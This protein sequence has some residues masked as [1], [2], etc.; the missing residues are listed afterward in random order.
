MHTISKILWGFLSTFICVI[1]KIDAYAVEYCTYP[2]VQSALV[3]NTIGTTHAQCSAATICDG[4]TCGGKW[5]N[6]IT[7][8]D[9]NETT[10]TIC[11]QNLYVGK[12]RKHNGQ[13]ATNPLYPTLC[14]AGY[15]CSSCPN[16]GV[17]GRSA[18]TI[19]WGVRYGRKIY[20]CSNTDPTGRSLGATYMQVI[21]PDCEYFTERYWAN[22]Y[23][24]Y[25]LQ[26]H[27]YRDTAGSYQFTNSCFYK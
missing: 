1:Y 20:F 7:E 10:T 22:I 16:S 15:I 25:L 21:E 14:S 26:N 12:C 19:S 8:Y 9:G 13:I 5:T 24:C 17:T 4:G 3:G 2:V 23:N 27:T 6:R 18:R 11:G